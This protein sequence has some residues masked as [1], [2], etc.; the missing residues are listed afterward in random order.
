M[1]P[2]SIKARVLSITVASIYLAISFMCALFSTDDIWGLSHLY[3]NSSVF[4]FA[5]VI[6]LLV[7]VGYINFATLASI[8]VSSRAKHFI[9]FL[10]LLTA[11]LLFVHFRSRIHL[12]GD[13]DLLVRDIGAL[14]SHRRLG[15]SFEPLWLF[16]V[17]RLFLLFGQA[18]KNA[19]LALRIPSYLS[20]LSFI[21]LVIIF[22]RQFALATEDSWLA[23]VALLSLG[24]MQLFFGYIEVYATVVAV[25]MLWMVLGTLE[26]FSLIRIFAMG[27][28]LGLAYLLH[29]SLIALT[30]SLLYYV[31]A[32]GKGHRIM[33]R[34]YLLIAA[35]LPLCI[36]VLGG[37]SLLGVHWILEPDSTRISHLLPFSGGLGHYAAYHLV[38]VGHFADLLN[39]CLL[40]CP[41]VIAL[42]PLS[43]HAGFPCDNKARFILIVA[44]GLTLFV[45]VANPEIGAFRD[46]DL[47][48]LPA[49]PITA[50]MFI[51]YGR[52]KG[53]PRYFKC[54]I[55]AVI[56]TTGASTI[57][58]IVVN[59]TPD[60]AVNRYA[61][62]L[63]TASLSPHARSYAWESLGTHY[64]KNRDL[65]SAA[66][67]YM[68]AVVADPDNPRLLSLAG[69][70]SHDVGDSEAGLN[71]L[72]RSVRA[73]DA[74]VPEYLDN[75]A[76][77]FTSI[78]NH[79]AAVSLFRRSVNVDP[80][81]ARRYRNLGLALINARE[82][83]AAAETLSAANRL[84][85][86]DTVVNNVLLRLK[87]QMEVQKEVTDPSGR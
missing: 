23:R 29:I 76:A 26:G 38:S 83:V 54:I 37:G 84:D 69:V 5:L 50:Y 53:R 41:L 9:A 3:L 85:P 43:L 81:N 12:L 32:A 35:L 20:G 63:S 11:T 6:E 77:V 39:I 79:P 60:L 19:E 67:A 44:A 30:P 86:S 52:T 2:L 59:A 45:F 28:L 57:S 4:I 82:Y 16:I 7:L 72:M 17:D 14:A 46:W 78:G 47:L 10:A 55:W 87:E 1:K 33:F 71:L 68:Q 73:S 80:G 58:W 25:V 13:G 40:A 24:T 22:T 65:P 70:A 75:L 66:E 51:V 36:I 18:D 48:A 34:L 74:K 31:Y 8:H 61:N 42:L 62:I 49:V 64:R 15:S 56:A 21:V 27:I